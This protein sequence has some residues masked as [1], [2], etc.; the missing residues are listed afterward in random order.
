MQRVN[1][2]F[3]LCT[4]VGPHDGEHISSDSGLHKGLQA[5][6]VQPQLFLCLCNNGGKDLII[7]LILPAYHPHPW[8]Y[9]CRGE[10]SNCTSAIITNS[11]QTILWWFGCK[12]KY[13]KKGFRPDELHSLCFVVCQL[14]VPCKSH[15]VWQDQMCVYHSEV[16]VVC[17]CT[18]VR[19]RLS[20]CA[21]VCIKC[22]SLPVRCD[23]RKK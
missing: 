14:S 21:F 17:V 2:L 15:S 6:C 9:L 11:I 12:I 3:T 23:P 8:V 22:V 19:S 7:E 5:V 13:Q 20:V 10:G 4:P 1:W 18:M 16:C